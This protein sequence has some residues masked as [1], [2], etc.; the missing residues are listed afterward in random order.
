LKSAI[1]HGSQLKPCNA[2]LNKII[3]K[4]NFTLYIWLWVSMDYLHF[5]SIHTCVQCI[6]QDGALTFECS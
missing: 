3:V 4:V 6:S 5:K 1:Q 2:I